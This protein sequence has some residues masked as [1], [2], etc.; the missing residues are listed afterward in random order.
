MTGQCVV[1]YAVKKGFVSS[2]FKLTIN[3][4]LSS[5]IISYKHRITAEIDVSK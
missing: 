1:D 3:K 2:Y 5:Y 4:Y